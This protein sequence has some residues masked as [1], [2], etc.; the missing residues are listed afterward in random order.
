MVLKD[1]VSYLQPFR[2][3]YDCAIQVKTQYTIQN[4][5]HH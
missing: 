4:V 1:K 5:A 2:Y 3:M